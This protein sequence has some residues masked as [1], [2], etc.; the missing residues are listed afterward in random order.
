[1]ATALPRNK[2][3]KSID[4]RRAGPIQCYSEAEELWPEPPPAIAAAVAIAD[5]ADAAD[6]VDTSVAIAGAVPDVVAELAV[7]APTA[8][9]SL[10][11]S[12]APLLTAVDDGATDLAVDEAKSN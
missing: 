8:C 6:T 10:A 2:W 9:A 1:M 3:R 4:Q 11:K 12:A 5:S 7:A